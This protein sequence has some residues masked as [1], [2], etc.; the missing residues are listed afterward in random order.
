MP[1]QVRAVGVHIEHVD[2]THG[3]WCNRCLLSTGLRVWV[4]VSH[5]GRMHL[6][7]QLYCYQCEGRYVTVSDDARHC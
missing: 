5:A 2:H 1:G 4:A 3:H 6:Q 7:E